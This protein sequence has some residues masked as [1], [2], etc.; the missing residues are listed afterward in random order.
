MKRFRRFGIGLNF[1]E[2]KVL[3]WLSFVENFAKMVETL[4]KM[5]Y[6][7]VVKSIVVD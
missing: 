7:V 4:M 2:L 3:C 6:F 1:L 5:Y